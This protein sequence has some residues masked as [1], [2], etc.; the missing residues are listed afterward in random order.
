MKKKEYDVYYV[1]LKGK[2]NYKTLARTNYLEVAF[3]EVKC[4]RREFPND[5][6]FVTKMLNDRLICH[7]FDEPDIVEKW[8]EYE[9]GDDDLV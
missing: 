6:F 8:H 5:T 4:L 1:V 2:D 3:E 7:R 9:K